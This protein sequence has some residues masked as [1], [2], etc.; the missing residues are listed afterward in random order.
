M[1]LPFVFVDCYDVKDACK[2][3][4]YDLESHRKIFR[5]SRSHTSDSLK[6]IFGANWD[7]PWRI[8]LK[9]IIKPQKWP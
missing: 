3:A 6:R 9:V 4:G 7:N 5:H 1:P 8:T 2:Y